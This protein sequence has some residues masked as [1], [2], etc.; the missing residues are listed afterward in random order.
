MKFG[1][2]VEHNRRN[3]FLVKRYSKCFGETISRHSFKKLKLS[4]PLDRWSKVLNSLSLLY[5]NLGTSEIY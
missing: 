2:L 4:I 5:A 3:I 1:Q